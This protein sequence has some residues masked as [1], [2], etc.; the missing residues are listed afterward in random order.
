[1]ETLGGILVK[2]PVHLEAGAARYTLRLEQSRTGAGTEPSGVTAL[3]LEDLLGKPVRIEH[4][5]AYICTRCGRPVNRLFGEGFCFP[6]FRDAPEAS[7]C[8][9][10]PELC[11]AHLEGDH[12][13]DPQWERDHHNQP[14]AV[15]F[16]RSSAL[17]VGVTRLT[18]IPTRW[19]D[20]GAAWAVVIARVPYRQLAGRIE[21]ALKD[22]YTDRTAWQRMLKDELA[23]E[24]DDLT[25]A[26]PE[27]M[28]RARSH[29]A[30]AD[31]E[32]SP[33]LLEPSR[34]EPVAISYPVLE[35]PV[36]VK[37]VSLAKT[38]VLESILQGVR[39]QYLIFEGGA[40]LNVRRHS[41]FVVRVSR[42]R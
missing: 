7:E 42:P 10:K 29:L 16:A 28:E 35:V 37:A 15:Y 14:H 3:D 26:L 30:G 12:G 9:V 32:L 4:A 24:P 2:M 33:F 5:G 27:E 36:K 34:A 21:V 23:A 20:Q 11:R 18:Q 17:K 19:I 31:P 41:G 38:P 6:C 22:L 25:R 40:V 1:M 39:G 13:R 8:I